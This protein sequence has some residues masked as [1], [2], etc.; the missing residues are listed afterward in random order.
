MATAK[1]LNGTVRSIPSKDGRP[2]NYAFVKGEDGGEYFLHASE[3]VGHNWEDLK[4]TI[5][6]K[7][8]A[9][10]NFIPSEGLKGPR[11][12]KAS[13][14]NTEVTSIKWSEQ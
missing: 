11:C 10:I 5:S 8:E 9:K 2:A 4:R 12:T 14:T 1:T 13:I 7:G 3:L 6:I